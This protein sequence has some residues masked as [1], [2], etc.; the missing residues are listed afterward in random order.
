MVLATYKDLCIDVSDARRMTHFWSAA[1][2]LGEETFDDGDSQLTGPTPQHGVW[3]NAVPEERSVK[4]RVHLDVVAGAVAD[5][6]DLG[7]ERLS[8]EGEFPW[9]VLADPEG[10][11]LCVFERTEVPDYRL[12]EIVVDAADPARI[13]RWWGAVL[14]GRVVDSERGFTYLDQIPGVPF[15]SFDLVPVPEP[16]AVKNRIHWDVVAPAVQPLLDAGARLVRDRDR[17]IEWTVLADPEGNEFCVF[18]G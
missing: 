12:Y 6:A 13:A 4:Q 14:G 9:T 10:G 18:T 3:I 17:E 2:G 7:A 15:D 8:A 1:L 16:K 11:E 5:L